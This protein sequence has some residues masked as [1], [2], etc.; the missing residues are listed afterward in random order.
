MLG[1]ALDECDSALKAYERIPN[2]D[3][4]NIL[5]VSYD[6][7]ETNE[8]EIFL[9]IACFFKGCPLRYITNMLEARGFH[10]KYGT[11]VLREKS[12]IKINRCFLER[13]F[14]TYE[15]VMMHDLIQSMG[16]EIVRQQSTWPQNRL[17]FYEDIDC[18]LEKDTVCKS[19][20]ALPLHN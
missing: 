17:W 3:V 13:Q 2:R 1:K 16:K 18:V 14:D 4:Q 8:K 11:R 20:L 15:I 19:H 12:L 7:L 5:R 9:D 10:P 6:S